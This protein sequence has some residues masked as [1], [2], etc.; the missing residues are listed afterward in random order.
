[1]RYQYVKKKGYVRL[2]T[3]KGDVNLELHCDK[4][5]TLMFSQEQTE[6]TIKQPD[7][8]L[9]CLR[10]FRAPQRRVCAQMYFLQ[11]G[12]LTS[13]TM[14]LCYYC[15]YLQVTLCPALVLCKISSQNLPSGTPQQNCISLPSVRGPVLQ[16]A[17]GRQFCSGYQANY[18]LHSLIYLF[19][20]FWESV[21]RIRIMSRESQ[22][23]DNL[24][25]LP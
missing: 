19:G 23:S 11:E 5:M 12:L 20:G 14:L 8:P 22:H 4:V 17:S 9:C 13:M 2:H 16:R 7:K 21:C 15:Y 24:P 1:M 3:N 25:S 10:Y 6:P 18:Q